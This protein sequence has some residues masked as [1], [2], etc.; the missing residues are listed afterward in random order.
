MI[1]HLLA[2]LLDVAFHHDSL[3]QIGN[4]G[5]VAAAV[6]HLLDDA[7]LLLKLSSGI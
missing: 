2:A 1:S 7:D 4:V 3:D 5:G 6:E